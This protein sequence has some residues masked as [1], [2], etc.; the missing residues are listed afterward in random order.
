[1][2]PSCTIRAVGIAASAGL[3]LA[4]LMA[5]RPGPLVST[6]DDPTSGVVGAAAWV[7]WALMGYLV[8]A[9]GAAAVAQLRAQPA[10]PGRLAVATRRVTPACVRRFVEAAVGV[11]TAAAVVVGVGPVAAS[12]DPPHPSHPAPVA[13]AATTSPL[14]WPGLPVALVSS[15]PR[16]HGGPPAELVVRAGDSLWT[17]AS[18][19]L[20]PGAS[21]TEI[22][23]AWPRLYA[24]NRAVI[25]TDPDLIHPG[26]RLVPPAPDLRR[27]R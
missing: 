25:G 15:H 23:A 2:R 10:G 12:A 20:G 27:P 7:A 17:L 9:V 24:A 8:T 21:A 19:Q 13:A 6:S 16:R 22:A 18:R 4:L 26:Q 5:H 1:M 14:D 11:S 3:A